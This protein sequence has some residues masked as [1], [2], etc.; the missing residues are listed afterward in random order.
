MFKK[1][2][3][4]YGSLLGNNTE[5]KIKKIFND[6]CQFITKGYIL[7]K[8][9][10]LGEYPGAIPT[11]NKN[12]RVFGKIFWVKNP[13]KTFRI[14]DEYEEYF[15]KNPKKSLFIRRKTKAYLLPS[16]NTIKCWAYLFN[17]KIE[18]QPQI[19]S[20]NYLKNIY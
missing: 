14:L 9:Y 18:I 6:N 4:L 10:D 11:T 3:F 15:P 16:E 20:G 2:L 8:L 13:R 12:D 19:N 5:E 17:Q 7:A 1:H